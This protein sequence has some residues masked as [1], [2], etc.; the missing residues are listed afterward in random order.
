MKSDIIDIDIDIF[1][2]KIFKFVLP[3]IKHPYPKLVASDIIDIDI[4][5]NE[6]KKEDFIK[7]EE[8]EV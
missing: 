4:F 8:F 2:D 7:K 6:I 3:I 5:R 1:K